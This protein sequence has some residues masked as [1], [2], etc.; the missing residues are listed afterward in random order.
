MCE[1][2]YW[3]GEKTEAMCGARRDEAAVRGRIVAFA[4]AAGTLWFLVGA[5]LEASGQRTNDR[6]RANLL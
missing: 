3:A 2:E 4:F 6:V 1:T 5:G